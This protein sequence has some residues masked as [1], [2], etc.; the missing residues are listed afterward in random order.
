[1]PRRP[2]VWYVREGGYWLSTSIGERSDKNGRRLGRRNLDIGP[3]TGRDGARN[4]AAAEL[5]L[6]EQLRAEAEAER[7]RCE[8]DPTFW[9]LSDLYLEWCSRR[10]VA[11]RTVKGYTERL[12]VFGRFKHQGIPYGKRLARDFKPADLR[13][14][15]ASIRADGCASTWVRDVAAAARAAMKWAAAP[16]DDRQPERLLPSNPFADVEGVKV[17]AP[18]KRYAGPLA[19]REFFDF[20]I[21]RACRLPTR[22][23]DWRW[24]RLTI[25][26]FR[27][28]EATGCRPSEARRLEWGHIDWEGR[29][30]TLKGKA[31]RSTGKK[32]RIPIPTD[33]L[34]ML[35]AIERLPDRHEQFVFTHEKRRKGG[36][37]ARQGFD[38]DPWTEDGLKQKFGRLRDEAVA[39]GLAIES[40]G[41]GSLTLYQLRRDLGADILRLTGSYA[42]SAEVLGHSAA[43]N[44]RHYS[45]FED[46]KAV[47]LA[48]AAAVRRK[49][50]S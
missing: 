10:G 41:A 15:V 21:V 29:V 19:R 46:R 30:A 35:R 8:S 4:R 38:G 6:N 39:A 3:P 2:S 48:E 50:K 9:T 18:P 11:E 23:K 32:R 36:G 22:F 42:H 47:D 25:A 27:F 31:T 1:M 16:I 45:S 49:G 37:D 34:R 28:C 44:E 14:I 7:D 24:E 40:E 20:L 13:R 26:L 33:T 43:M 17:E 12:R 5:W